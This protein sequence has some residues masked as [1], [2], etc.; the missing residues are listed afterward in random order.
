VSRVVGL[1][2]RLCDPDHIDA[3]IELC[4]RG[5]R[6]RPDV[7]W[8]LFERERNAA[9]L[10]EALRTEIWRPQRFELLFIRDPK[11]RVIARAGIADRVLHTALAMLMEPIVLRS[12]SPLDFACRAGA[13]QHRALLS[14]LR[15]MRR[16][17]FALHLDV[18]AYFP[19]VDVAVL[20]RLLARRIDDSQ[21]LRV[22]DLVL[23]S[24]RGLYDSRRA[25][26]WAKLP[27]TWPPPGRGLPIG[28]VTSQLL[29]AHLYL[30]DLDHIATRFWQV[31]SYL[32]YVDDIFV[33]GDGRAELRRWRAQIGDWLAR[34][35]GLRLKHPAARILSCAGHLDALGWRIRREGLEPLPAMLRRIRRRV[36]EHL[37]GE[38]GLESLRRSMMA[39]LGQGFVF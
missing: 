13:G 37:H 7:A 27:E 14:L 8:F 10:V 3:A 34:E 23:E 12:A 18:R 6:G 32:R 2:A 4:T 35:R 19:S 30:Q 31:G 38:L 22:I 9:R 20:R 33:F 15:A 17:R 24:G 16:F 21:F 39:T 11:P 28:A 5:K 25:R 26:R 1:H 36:S 29:A